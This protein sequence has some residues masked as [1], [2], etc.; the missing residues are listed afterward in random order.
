MTER[1]DDGAGRVLDSLI[2]A[3]RD[4]QQRLQDISSGILEKK[5]EPPGRDSTT[6]MVLG[7]LALSLVIALG[8]L[9]WAFL[10]ISQNSRIQ[11]D[12]LKRVEAFDDLIKTH[13]ITVEQVHSLQ[14]RLRALEEARI[15][16]DQKAA[17]EAKEAKSPPGTPG[18]GKQ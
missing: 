10:D 12:L 8:L 1:T 5:F 13:R 15:Q 2:Q 4:L 18:P 17:K 6:N 7:L 9:V 14:N 11:A 16:A 3:N